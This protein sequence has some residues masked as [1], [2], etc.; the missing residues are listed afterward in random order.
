[1][2][3]VFAIFR[4]LFRAV[5]RNLGTFGSI[6]VNNFFL[7]VVLLIAGAL[8]SGV[9]PVS[10][11]PFL[12]LLGLLMLFPLSSDP[13]SQ[14][15]RTRLTLWPLHARERA[16]LRLGS[17]ALSPV[18][19]AAAVILVRTSKPLPAA[20]LCGMAVAARGLAAPQWA[21]LRVLPRGPG[22]LGQ[23]MR[24][25]LRQ[26]FTVLD[27]W[28]AVLISAGAA[29]WRIA[30]RNPDPDAFPILSILVALA[31][32]TYAQCLFSLD[33]AAGLTRYRLLP[34][35]GR[36][37]L[38]AKDAAYLAVLT[39]LLLPLDIA[40]GFTFGLVSLA[41]GRYPAVS[42]RIPVER[43]RFTSGRIRFGVLQCVVG[44]ALATAEARLGLVWL[45]AAV[46]LYA[47]SY[48]KQD[49]VVRQ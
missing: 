46:V 2:T 27:T 19:W 40:A 17:L 21:P 39:V 47:A 5:R 23:L 37:I 33:S 24:S 16:G 4:A 22:R 41:A 11:Y 30:A 44:I 49:S 7:F 18:F 12:L 36:E 28:V 10:S 6:K 3:A 32:S 14:I 35:R 25:N 45:L 20:A 29:V 34:L 31:L 26:M 38:F 8:S 9:M 42:G 13:L 43:W 15:P 1:V 48:L